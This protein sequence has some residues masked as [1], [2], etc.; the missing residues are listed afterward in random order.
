MGPESS[1][2]GELYDRLAEVAA[3]E[4][5]AEGAADVVDSAESVFDRH[6]FSISNPISQYLA[7]R[8]LN[9]YHADTIYAE[10]A[11]Y[12]HDPN[13]VFSGSSELQA[14]LMNRIQSSRVP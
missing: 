4:Q 8:G 7:G 10:M 2:L 12:G 13:G 14:A 3:G 11:R 6:N 9:L 5:I 1:S